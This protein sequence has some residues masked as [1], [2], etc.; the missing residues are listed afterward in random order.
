M[1]R[2]ERGPERSGP[3]R[4]H[5]GPL[6]SDPP[7]VHLVRPPRVGPKSAAA[8][9]PVCIAGV[10]LTA[11]QLVVSRVSTNVR[12]YDVAYCDGIIKEG[13]D[14]GR[15]VGGHDTIATSDRLE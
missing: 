8:V 14:N 11:V 10:H 2:S 12:M 13:S 9:L 3:K 5:V 6:R 15:R 1:D 7:L 4:Y